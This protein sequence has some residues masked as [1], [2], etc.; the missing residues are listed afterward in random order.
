MSEF[1]SRKSFFQKKSCFQKSL[2][3]LDNTKFLRFRVFAEGFVGESRTVYNVG[4]L[5]GLALANVFN[6]GFNAG[7]LPWR[8]AIDCAINEIKCRCFLRKPKM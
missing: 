4:N 8:P 3:T 2:M 6:A 1:L 7:F 5:R